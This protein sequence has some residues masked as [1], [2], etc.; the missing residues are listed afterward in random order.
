MLHRSCVKSPTT[1]DQFHGRQFFHRL[2]VG[3]G[4]WFGD[5]LSTLQ[6]LCIL[7]L[8]SLHQL[9]LRSPGIKIP[10]VGDPCSKACE[11]S[12]ENYCG[13][14]RKA[15]PRTPG[16]PLETYYHYISSTS[17]HQALRFR[18][19]GTPVLRHVSSLVRTIVEG[20]GRPIP[21]HQGAP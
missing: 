7:F 6:L 1:R 10:E 18:R 4:G 11:F 5:D 19:L 14:I 16:C 21:G 2:G 12:G 20:S 17:D 9:H 3:V 15:Y 13:R 8:L